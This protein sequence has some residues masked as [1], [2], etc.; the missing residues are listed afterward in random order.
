MLV[1]LGE[2]VHFHRAGWLARMVDVWRRLGSGMYGFWSS[3]LVRP[4]LNT[5]GFVVDPVLLRLYRNKVVT[6]TDRYQF[7]HGR[8]AFWKRVR[9]MGKPVRLVTWDGD[10]PPERWRQPANILWRGDQSNCLAYCSHTDNYLAA[11]LETRRV[12][13]RHIDSPYRE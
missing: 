7:E 8:Y 3:N 4:H 5:T 6:K 11:P 12:W 13:Q 9:L 1:C 10:W 2:S